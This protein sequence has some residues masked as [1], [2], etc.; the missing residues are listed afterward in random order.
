MQDI[1]HDFVPLNLKNL[2]T[3][4]AS[5]HSYN[6]RAAA[7]DKFHV[8]HSRQNSRTNLSQGLELQPGTKSPSC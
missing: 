3:R 8:I 1:D 6:T 7:A 4:I 2:F 5:I